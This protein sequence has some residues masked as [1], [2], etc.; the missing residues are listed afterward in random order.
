[1]SNIGK[2]LNDYCNGYFGRNSYGEKVIIGEGPEWI[3]V[4]EEI[5][6]EKT[7]LNFAS[8]DSEAQKERLLKEWGAH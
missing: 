7:F 8:F 5:E 1:M 3:V 2:I 6:D 4:R